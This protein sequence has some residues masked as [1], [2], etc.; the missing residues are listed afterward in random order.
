MLLS[1]TYIPPKRK[2]R[3]I[4]LEIQF[5]SEVELRQFLNRMRAPSEIVDGMEGYQGHYDQQLSKLLSRW[6][7]NELDDIC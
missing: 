7:R 6:A 3:K 4:R 2:F 5:D 1:T